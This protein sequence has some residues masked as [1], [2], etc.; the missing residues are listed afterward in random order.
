MATVPGQPPNPILPI[1]WAND[2]LHHRYHSCSATAHLRKEYP[3]VLSI[4]TSKLT[5]GLLHFGYDCGTLKLFQMLRPLQ[6]VEPFHVEN[7]NN[8]PI[9]VWTDGTA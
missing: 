6:K 7:D 5:T 1:L 4:S 2:T 8:E 3:E 9:W